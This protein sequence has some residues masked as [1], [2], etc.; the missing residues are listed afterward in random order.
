MSGCSRHPVSL[1]EILENQLQRLGKQRIA[2]PLKRDI[3]II[4]QRNRLIEKWLSQLGLK[5]ESGQM[6][7]EEVWAQRGITLDDRRNRG[8][9]ESNESKENDKQK[10][11]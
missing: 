10:D 6:T 9:K 3:W 4:Q 2:C 11:E 8:E 7:I 5:T 1:E